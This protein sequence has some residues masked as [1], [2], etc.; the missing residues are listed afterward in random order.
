MP[1]L[2]LVELLKDFEKMTFYVCEVSGKVVGVCALY[3]EEGRGRLRWVYVLPGFQRRGI[4]TALVKLAESEAKRA[5]IKEL[6]LTTAEKASWALSFYEKL[7]YR[8]V[9]VVERSWGRDVVMEKFL[10]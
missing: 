4:G 5:G 2:T 9:R 10:E 7:G 8:V 1:V 6:W 3:A